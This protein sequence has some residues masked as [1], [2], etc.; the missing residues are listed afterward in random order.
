MYL[1][2][3]HKY[4]KHYFHLIYMRSIIYCP[5]CNLGIEVIERNCCIFRCGIMKVDYT[6]IPPHL[7]KAECDK[8]IED[9]KIYGC[10]KPFK[11]VMI[12]NE[13]KPIICDYI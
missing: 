9:D 7:S 10:G 13:W 2:Y 5:H 3:Y 12:E 1:L 4:N 8:L 6:Q 11:L